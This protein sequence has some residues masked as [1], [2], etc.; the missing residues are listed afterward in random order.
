MDAIKQF[1]NFLIEQVCG[2]YLLLILS[3]MYNKLKKPLKVISWFICCI[4]IFILFSPI[5]AY[6]LTSEFVDLIKN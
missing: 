6:M 4:V 5:F 1:L 3:K 2:Y